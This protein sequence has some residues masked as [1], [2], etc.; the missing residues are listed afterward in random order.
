[1]IS[2]RFAVSVYPLL[3][4]VLSVLGLRLRLRF[5]RGGRGLWLY[6]RFGGR[7]G[8]LLRARRL[9]LRGRLRLGRFLTRLCRRLGF[10]LYGGSRLR[11]RFGLWGG[12]GFRLLMSSRSSGLR[13]RRCGGSFF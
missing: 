7:G 2:L 1:M 4:A 9:C 11:G 8:R 5:R 6:L 12:L 13:L 3:G 10:R